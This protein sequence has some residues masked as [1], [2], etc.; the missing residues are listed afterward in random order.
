MKGMRELAAQILVIGQIQD[1]MEEAEALDARV[2]DLYDNVLD[3]TYAASTQAYQSILVITSGLEYSLPRIVQTLH[4]HNAAPVYVLT[5][6]VD[7]P[8]VRTLVNASDGKGIHDYLTGPVTLSQVHGM[9]FPGGSE[10]TRHDLEERLVALEK[11]ATED[12]LTGLKNRRYIWEFLRQILVRA[13]QDAGRVTLM[14]YDIDDFKHYNDRYGHPTG[15]LILKEAAVLMRSCCRAH[16]VIGR[17][18]GDEFA[19]IF[20]DDPLKKSETASLE[21][22]LD[23]MDH[24]KEPIF[25]AKRFQRALENSDLEL[26]GTDGTGV[27]TISGGLASYPYDGETVEQLFEKADE[28]LLEAKRSGKNRVYLVGSAQHD[29]A[30]YDE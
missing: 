28:A 17:I 20:W 2:F 1:I 9:L 21:R 15:D 23:R 3:G 13:Q 24:P 30:R 27:L 26:L 4:R 6:I 22:R 12:D 16:D 10:G 7:E 5:D 18:G 11:L 25:I 14:V 19:V 29:I 8:E